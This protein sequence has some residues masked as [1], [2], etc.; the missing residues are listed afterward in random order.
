MTTEVMK[1]R[2]LGQSRAAAP[3]RVWANPIYFYCDKLKGSYLTVDEDLFPE[4]NE[5][6]GRKSTKFGS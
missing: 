3:T 4:W 6:V 2:W 1:G 5:D